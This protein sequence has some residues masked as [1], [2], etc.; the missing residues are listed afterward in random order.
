MKFFY[1]IQ[2][3]TVTI[4]LLLFMILASIN[5]IGV[6]GAP[7]QQDEILI[8]GTV[9]DASSNEPLPGVSIMVKGTSAG[10]VTDLNGKYSIHILPG[11]SLQ[12]SFIGYLTEEYTITNATELPVLLVPDIIGLEEIV[13]VGY[14]IQ[15]KSDITGSIASVSGDELNRIPVAGV[16]QALQGLA[17][18]VN[19]LSVSGRPGEEAVIQIRGISSINEIEPLI[20]I[21][22]VPGSL[23][24]VVPSE[25]ES[26]E[27]LK[28]A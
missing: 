13:V 11:A 6:A 14:G 2:K 16:D 28:D 27:V 24:D 10:T 26:I 15:K 7:R 4:W 3:S 1:M 23:Q 12:F 9:T 22:C 25:I 19:I 18:G 20:I 17:A 8:S 21:D 5:I